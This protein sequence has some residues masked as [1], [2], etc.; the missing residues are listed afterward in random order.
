[1]AN[2]S[3]FELFGSDDS[4]EEDDKQEVGSTTVVSD[5]PTASF[6]RSLVDSHGRRIAVHPASR[7]SLLDTNSMETRLKPLSDNIKSL[8]QPKYIGPI[9][10]KCSFDGKN[11]GGGRGFVAATAIPPG[12]LLL[13]ERPVVLW[14][15][16]GIHNGSDGSIPF[17]IKVLA[18]LLKRDDAVTIFSAMECLYPEKLEDYADQS[19]IEAL[20][21]DEVHATLCVRLPSMKTHQTSNGVTLSGTRKLNPDEALRLVLAIRSNSFASGLYLHFA[22]FNHTCMP[23]CIKYQPQRKDSG[24]ESHKQNSSNPISHEASE[25]RATRWIA[26]GE[27]LTLSYLLPREQSRHHRRTQLWDQFRFSCRCSLCAAH[28]TE[29]E[30]IASKSSLPTYENRSINT[31]VNHESS[32]TIARRDAALAYAK[33]AAAERLCAASEAEEAKLQLNIEEI[34]S[35]ISAAAATLSKLAPMGGAES[36]ESGAKV[37]TRQGARKLALNNNVLLASLSVSERAKRLKLVAEKMLRRK[38]PLPSLNT[39][40]EG[41][42]GTSGAREHILYMRVVRLNVDAYAAAIAAIEPE[43]DL[44]WGKKTPG[45]SNSH[46]N[47]ID[48]RISTRREKIVEKTLREQFQYLV[49]NFLMA[50]VDLRHEQQLMLG[51]DHPDL[52]RTYHDISSGLKLLLRTSPESF[53]VPL[54]TSTDISEID[55]AP[56]FP[57]PE[58]STASLARADE[59]KHRRAHER[60]KAIYSGY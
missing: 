5:A 54:D 35:D 26:A 57:L 46:Q 17:E 43:L 29:E 48:V 21:A 22:M 58:W 30:A 25:V 2:E 12:T 13:A 33:A 59:Q 32:I 3:G 8:V 34:E 9:V 45:D 16:L 40:G 47:D 1:M 20:R 36:V 10:L 27:E 6:H 44:N 38:I 51:K 15:E 55:P 56:R 37:S 41:F 11:V 7:V 19:V 53:Q 42:T 28:T 60:L 49:E 52:A 39:D 23:N 14:S 31:S 18:A 4:D 24:K 50:T